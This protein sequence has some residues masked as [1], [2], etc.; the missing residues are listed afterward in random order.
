MRSLACHLWLT[1]VINLLLLLFLQQS[2]FGRPNFP[3]KVK[4]F[5][6]TMVLNKANTNDLLQIRRPHMA[7]SPNVCVF[8]FKE[9]ETHSHLF[10]LCPMARKMRSRLLAFS[11]EQW[12]AP[13][14][15]EDLLNIGLFGFSKNKDNRSLWKCALFSTLQYLWLE[16]NA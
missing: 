4:A 6:W 16:R 14:R 3:F 5:A 2:S 10:L 1:L 7:L 13:K 11:G 8:C 12:V 15:V 9:E